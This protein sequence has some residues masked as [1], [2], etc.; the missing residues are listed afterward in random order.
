MELKP[1]R[2]RRGGLEGRRARTTGI[3]NPLAASD[4]SERMSVERRESM[5]SEISRLWKHRGKVA[6][7]SISVH[8]HVPTL[9][10]DFLRSSISS[11]QANNVPTLPS[12]SNLHPYPYP[13]LI[14][15]KKTPPSIHPQHPPSTLLYSTLLY[16]TLPYPIHPSTPSLS[17]K[18]SSSQHVFILVQSA[19]APRSPRSSRRLEASWPE[20]DRIYAG[21][22]QLQPPF[23]LALLLR[24]LSEPRVFYFP[25]GTSRTN[26][27]MPTARRASVITT[28]A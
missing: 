9:P 1:S 24:H 5:G 3:R 11:V 25:K 19:P 21:T 22:L 18:P 23:F 17:Q 15:Q 26:C 13:Y 4:I 16:S 12:C 7:R 6:S 2:R 8:K 27:T 28:I 20:W 14:L 10:S